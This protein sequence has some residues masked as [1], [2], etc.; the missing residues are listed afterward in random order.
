[1]T[2]DPC[3]IVYHYDSVSNCYKQRKNMKWQTRKM[4]SQITHVSSSYVRT[5]TLS[6]SQS[7]V[8]VVSYQSIKIQSLISYWRCLSPSWLR[9]CLT[10]IS[11]GHYSLAA[12]CYI[13]FSRPNSRRIHYGHITVHCSTIHFRVCL[14]VCLLTS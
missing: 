4:F 3:I 14:C 1:M 5:R 12:D 7:W 2:H 13:F 9:A 11:T 10:T 8:Y 6:T